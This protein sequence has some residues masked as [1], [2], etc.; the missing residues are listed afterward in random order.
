MYTEATPLTDD[1]KPPLTGKTYKKINWLKAGI[2]ATDKVVTVSPNYATEISAN[3]AGGV[4]LDT[5]IRWDLTYDMGPC[6]GPDYQCLL[7]FFGVVCSRGSLSVELMQ[8]ICTSPNP[9][10]T[11]SNWSSIDFLLLGFGD[12]PQPFAHA[13]PD[14]LFPLPP[15]QGQGH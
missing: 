12:L 4:E 10:D 13:L 15:P 8:V 5:Y 11:S 1:E 3:A 14:A 9:P 2:L 6:E 7:S